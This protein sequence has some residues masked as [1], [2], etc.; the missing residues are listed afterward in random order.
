MPK[1]TTDYP[2]REVGDQVVVNCAWDDRHG[3]TGKVFKLDPDTIE[4]FWVRF[5]DDHEAG[6]HMSELQGAPDVC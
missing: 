5:P 2:W 3:Q 1:H 6:Y 4:F